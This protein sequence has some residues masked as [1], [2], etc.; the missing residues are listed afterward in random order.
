M[1]ILMHRR[2]CL[3]CVWFAYNIRSSIHL[4]WF[5][6]LL[7]KQ[8]DSICDW[9]WGIFFHWISKVCILFMKR[10]AIFRILS[11]AFSNSRIHEHPNTDEWNLWA[12]EIKDKLFVFLFPIPV[13]VCCL[14]VSLVIWTQIPVWYHLECHST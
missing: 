10:P 2:F 11:L 12:K 6:T 13:L 14:N 9:R 1:R 4:L 3:C 8:T 7:S 5:F